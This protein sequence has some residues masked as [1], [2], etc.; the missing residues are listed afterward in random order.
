M[1][2]TVAISFMCMLLV[3]GCTTSVHD[4][5]L[6]YPIEF[7]YDFAKDMQNWQG[8][9]SDYPEGEEVSFELEI[10]HSSLP[11]PLD[12]SQGAI[13]QSGNNH[14]DDLFMF[15]K[16]RLTG[17]Q[18]NR[19]YRATFNIQIATNVPDNVPGVGGSPGESVYI[20]V[21]LTQ[22]EPTKQIN[23]DGQY[24]MNLDKGNQA[25]DGKD[26]V[27]IGDFSNNTNEAIYHL[28]NLDNQEV[29]EIQSDQN[30]ELW[31]IIGTDSGF[32]ATTTIFYNKIS[33]ILES[34]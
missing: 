11:I 8:G 27:L 4:P 31:A 9:F 16:R 32:E 33:I 7:D 30:G 17:L 29:F 14:S 18:P 20:K 5:I 10:E 12:E 3:I 1:K 6:D 23:N 34:K 21:G 24:I 15:I 13:R 25:E 2:K 28:K 22:T 19:T 26:M